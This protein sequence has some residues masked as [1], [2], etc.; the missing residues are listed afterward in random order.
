MHSPMSQLVSV[1]IPCYNQAHFLSAAIESILNQTYPH[2]EIIAVNDGSTDN[3]AE[4][5]TRN[6]KVRYFYQ[7]NQ[8]LPAARNAGAQASRGAYLVFLDAD[9]LLLPNALED[10]VKCLREHPE[11]GLV[12]GLYELMAEDGAPLPLDARALPEKID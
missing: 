12:Y 6:A 11:C 2:F 10:G 3:T 8:G 1:I 9:D 4:I 7:P 5:A